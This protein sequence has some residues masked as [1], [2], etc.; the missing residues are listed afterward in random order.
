MKDDDNFVSWWLLFFAWVV[1]QPSD[2][3]LLTTGHKIG[4]FLVV[5]SLLALVIPTIWK[6]VK[7]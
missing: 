7:R 6:V 5:A 3:V 1:S 4:A 2:F